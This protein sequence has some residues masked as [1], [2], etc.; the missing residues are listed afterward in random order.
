MNE[1]MRADMQKNSR[2]VG[3]PEACA[4]VVDI[5]MSLMKQSAAN[6]G[7]LKSV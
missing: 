7:E 5:A 4:K 2:A 3:R 1:T 6:K